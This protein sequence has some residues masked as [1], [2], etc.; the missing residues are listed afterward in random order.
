M[1]RHH[2]FPRCL[3][4]IAAQ[5][6]ARGRGEQAD[7]GPPRPFTDKPRQPGADPLVNEPPRSVSAALQLCLPAE[8]SV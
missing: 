6:D 7:D 4:L 2:G 8:K 1:A 3:E 5:A